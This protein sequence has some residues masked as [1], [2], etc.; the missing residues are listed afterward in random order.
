MS[1]V[2][3]FEIPSDNPERS[4]AFYGE[5]F[6]WKFEKWDGPMP[7]WLVSTGADGEVG[8]NGGLKGRSHPGEST[9]NTVGVDS[10]DESLRAI[11]RKGGKTVVPKMAVPGI[12][13]LAYCSDP[14]GNTFGVLQADAC[15]K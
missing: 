13:W 7:Y 5:V 1:R 4:V 12:G 14:D 9:V 11:E 8:I 10:V 2:I 6:G 3:H 15:A